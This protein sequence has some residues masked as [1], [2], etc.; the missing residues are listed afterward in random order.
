[1]ITDHCSYAPAIV[2]DAGFFGHVSKRSIV[3]VAEQRSMRW[4]RLAAHGVVG[5]AIHQIDIEPS[6]I[7]VIKERNAGAKGL[8]D[9]AFLRRAHAMSPCCE[10]GSL[11]SISKDHRA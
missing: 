9:V 8:D 1:K 2:R 3:I 4:C 11:C 10:P 6:I 7:V 5:R